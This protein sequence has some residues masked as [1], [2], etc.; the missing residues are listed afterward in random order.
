MMKKMATKKLQIKVVTVFLAKKKVFLWINK[1]GENKMLG[2]IY[3]TIIKISEKI[4][5]NFM[6]E[7]I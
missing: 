7:L 3:G 1:N 6:T 4:T 5:T 2:Q